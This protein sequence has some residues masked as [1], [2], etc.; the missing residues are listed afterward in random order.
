VEVLTGLRKALAG[1][2][3][4]SGV[5]ITNASPRTIMA[6]GEAHVPED[7]HQFGMVDSFPVAANMILNTYFAPPFSTGISMK[8]DAI[9]E[10]ANRLVKEFDIRTPSI[11]LKAGSLSGGNQQKLVVA[12]EFSRPIKVLIASQPTRGLDVGS[13]EFIHNRIVQKRDEGCAVLLVSAELDE[14]MSLSDRIAVMYRGQIIDTL[15]ARATTRES[16]GLL[17]AGMKSKAQE[18]ESTRVQA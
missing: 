7:R 15:D 3:E 17:M 5:N 9:V 8:E 13:I 11:F 16:V 10:Q 12:R 1:V 2:V 6:Q 18:Q 14:I 4:I